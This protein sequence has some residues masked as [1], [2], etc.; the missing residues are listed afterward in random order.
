MV[1]VKAV[2]VAVESMALTGEFSTI[3]KSELA[4]NKTTAWATS[5][6]DL[7]LLRKTKFS[8]SRYINGYVEACMETLGERRAQPYS[9]MP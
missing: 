5:A 9:T 7:D 1:L 8:E 3:T 2:E 4:P 6:K